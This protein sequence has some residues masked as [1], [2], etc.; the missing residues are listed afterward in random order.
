MRCPDCGQENIAG[1]EICQSCDAPLADLA[2][3]RAKGGVQT[4]I[5]EGTIADVNPHVAIAVAGTS[6]VADA[7]KL[8]RSG[9]MGCVLVMQE[10]ALAGIFTERDLLMK[11][12][13]LKDPAQV[14]LADV[15]NHDPQCLSDTDSIAFAFHNMALKGYRHIPISRADGSLGIIS[16]RD[17]LRYLC[18]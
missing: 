14:R 10:G 8:M 15:M 4:K 9:K 7:I 11:I 6:T 2:M 12:A 16:S 3:P 18:R 17:L 1:E 13:G 5:I